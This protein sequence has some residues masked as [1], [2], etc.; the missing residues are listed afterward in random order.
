MLRSKTFLPDVNVWLAFAVEA[1][2]HHR[3]AM[4]W[5]D[6]L[7]RSEAAFCRITQMGV[8]RLLT[9]P[10]VMH[11]SVLSQRGAWQVYETLQNDERA[12]F[13]DEPGGIEDRW[14]TLVTARSSSG[15]LWTDCYLRAFAETA[16][17]TIATFDRTLGSH[18][19]TV[20]L[21]RS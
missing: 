6:S 21:G 17:L 8:L 10:K 2:V 7:S 9:N 19:G 12:A 13:L 1:H 18:A 3:E 14:K 20:L 4:A 15:S 5:M 11:A 16:G